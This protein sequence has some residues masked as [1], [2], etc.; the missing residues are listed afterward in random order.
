MSGKSLPAKCLVATLVLKAYEQSQREKC[1]RYQGRS[2]DELFGLWYWALAKLGEC[3]TFSPA[4]YEPLSHCFGARVMVTLCQTW[5]IM[6]S[7]FHNKSHKP[8][9]LI[10][11]CC[12]GMPLRK[13][14][15]GQW[16]MEDPKKVV[17]GHEKRID[18]SSWPVSNPLFQQRERERTDGNGRGNIQA[19]SD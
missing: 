13:L 2:Y 16:P 3:A 19:G 14:R 4:F 11:K 5:L 6:R 17:V 8:L 10:L 12:P 18:S 15:S 7:D 9:F 1:Q